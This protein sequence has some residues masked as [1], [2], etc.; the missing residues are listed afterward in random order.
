MSGF[1]GD[2][3]AVL[4]TV[5]KDG[6]PT[7]LG[8]LDPVF[9]EVDKMVYRGKELRYLNVYGRA[10]GVAPN[11]VIA[12]S[13]AAQQG[14]KNAEWI[15]PLDE[16][17][18]FGVTVVTQKQILASKDK[19]GA[20]QAIG[21]N[22][23]YGSMSGLRRQAAALFYSSGLGEFGTAPAA[24]TL[25]VGVN[26]IV[27]PR[28]AVVAIDI[29]SRF[30][31]A[32]PLTGL[33]AAN[34]SLNIV[35]A[36]GPAVGGSA[37]SKT[38]TFTATA[39]DT[40][41]AGDL[42]VY[43]GNHNGTLATPGEVIAPHGLESLFPS[44]AANRGS[45]LF[46]IDRS[47]YPDRLSGQFINDSGLAKDGTLKIA[48][49]NKAVNEIRQAAGDSE[50]TVVLSANDYAE[51]FA[52]LNAQERYLQTPGNKER[53]RIFKFGISDME[54][55]M[56]T[57]WIKRVVD[58]PFL[59]DGKGYILNVDSL[60]IVTYSNW[61]PVETND[62]PANNEPG[63]DDPL[64]ETDKSEE[65]QRVNIDDIFS[66]QPATDSPDGNAAEVT[67][68]LFYDLC[69]MNPAHNAV[70]LFPAA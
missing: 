3:R 23:M 68:S 10:P 54:F 5:Y 61:G 59:Q 53:E 70:F 7:L 55:S 64:A 67:A 65:V 44:V 17:Q 8:R 1:I 4:K 40:V 28:S 18:M 36:I 51:V 39:A 26:T 37:G 57:T 45:S 35:T 32:D 52:E 58:T 69:C 30:Q 27:L 22:L 19:A 43:Y 47:V 25:T 66:I 62:G 20:Y 34:A 33:P 49:I 16:R 50:F 6:V 48:T 21:Q 9:K 11:K 41:N 14:T 15:V 24:A 60:K 13:I 31:F 29:G 46:G 12:A 63:G 2:I 56:A 42:L 38:V